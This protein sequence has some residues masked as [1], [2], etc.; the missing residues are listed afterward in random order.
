MN[1]QQILEIAKNDPRFSKAVLTLENEIGDMPVTGESLDEL[2]KMLEFA[3]NNPEN[4]AE[5]VASAV[6]DDMIEEGD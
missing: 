5:I 4:Y 6:Q 2:V 1:K 3:L